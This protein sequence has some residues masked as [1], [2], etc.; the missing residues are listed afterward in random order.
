MTFRPLWPLGMYIVNYDYIANVLCE[1]KDIPEMK[2]N[3]KCY[4]S[5]M[6]ARDRE[7][8]KE[9]PFETS[10]LKVDQSPIV[11][12]ELHSF[13]FLSNA[14]EAI[15]NR[16]QDQTKELIDLL[17]VFEINKP[18]QVLSAHSNA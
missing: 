15:E 7:Q 9:N 13:H 5:K 18:P 6:I 12:L 4:L 3:G 1:N 2:C 10:V 11:V 14:F 16:P 17:L 8:N